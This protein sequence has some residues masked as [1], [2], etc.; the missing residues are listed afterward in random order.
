MGPPLAYPREGRIR[1]DEYGAI[2]RNGCSGDTA[3]QVIDL[4]GDP[5][6][7]SDPRGVLPPDGAE[8][9]G[10]IPKQHPYGG[11]GY[12]LIA[13]AIREARI[14]ELGVYIGRSQNAVVQFISTRTIMDLCLEA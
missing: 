3:F 4:G 7:G 5:P 6:H 14:E 10:N 12:P 9:H 1:P 8:N 13:E 11:W 2:L